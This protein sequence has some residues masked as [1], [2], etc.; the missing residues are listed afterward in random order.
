MKCPLLQV[1]SYHDG[2]E[3]QLIMADCLKE[4]CAWWGKRENF[5]GTE[6]RACTL[7]HIG[8][9]LAQIVSALSERRQ[10]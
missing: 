2:Q 5:D 4:E 1:E 3:I 9:A 8:H 7:W 6:I 10:P